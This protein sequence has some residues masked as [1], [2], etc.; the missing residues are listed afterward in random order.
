MNS[1]RRW[2]ARCD[3]PLATAYDAALLDLDGVVYVGADAV[4]GAAAAVTAAR[5]AGMQVAFVTNNASRTPVAVAEHLVS[6]G[7]AA[8]P[9][10]VATAAQAAAR[11]LVDQVPAGAKVLVVGGAG[12]VEAVRGAGFHV[13]TSADDDPAAVLQ[14][15]T[16]D[17][18]YQHLA[19]ATL[20][21][22]RGAV[23]ITAN[24]DATMPSSRGQVPGNG[25]LVAAVAVATGREPIVAGKPSTALHAE[26]VARVAASRPLVVGDRLD[27]DIAG[28]TAVGC[29]SLLVLTGVTDL[30]LLRRAG[31]AE[32]PTYLAADLGG[33]LCRH[34]EVEVEVEAA[35]A[36]CGSA[37]ARLDGGRIVSA[38]DGGDGLDAARA[39]LGLW[40]FLADGGAGPG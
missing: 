37:T 4:R 29:D 33:L 9:D 26:S 20:A 22:R 30:A 27:T 14:G 24:R 12:L 5:G 17:T 34:H 16:V 40:W 8:A 21:V 10:E 11:I 32:R 18:T 1:A 13:V 19:E 2:L 35:A 36:R 7:V 3:E 15:Y 25:A 28:A 39:E 6:L 38:G 31:P 23:W